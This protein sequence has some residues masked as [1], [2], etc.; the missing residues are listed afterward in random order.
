MKSPA[1]EK[2]RVVAFLRRRLPIPARM[3][4][5]LLAQ[6]RAVSHDPAISPHCL[7]TGFYEVAPGALMCQLEFVAAANSRH[8]MVAPL[9][10]VAFG[11]GHPV[12]R[13][14]APLR[15]Q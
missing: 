8:V 2:S 9:S 15:A 14:V 12:S 5:A 11:R 6:A 3:R 4:P 1:P 10:H 13:I 7:V